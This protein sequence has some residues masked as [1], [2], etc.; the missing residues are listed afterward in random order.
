MVGLEPLGA[1][2][3]RRG[4]PA[5]RPRADRRRGR[6]GGGAGRPGRPRQPAPAAGVRTGSPGVQDYV[7][8]GGERQVGSARRFGALR[9]EPR[10]RGALRGRLRARGRGD[11][12]H[13]GDQPRASCSLR[14][15][16]LSIARSIVRPIRALSDG[17]RRI[18]QGETDSRDPRRRRPRR[19]R[20]A[21]A[22]AARDGRPP[23]AATRSSSSAS[24]P[25]SNAPTPSCSRERT[26]SCAAA[27]SCWSSS[28][29]RTGSPAST[30]TATSRTACASRSKRADRTGEPL[31]LLLIDID[32]FKALNDRHGHAV[33]DEVLR[34][35]ATLLNDSVRETDLP[36]RYGGEEFAVLAPRT[37]REGAIALAEKLARRRSAARFEA[38]GGARTA[39]SRHRL[40]R[41]RRLRRRRAA[42][43]QRRRSRALPG[44]GARAR[45]ACVFAGDVDGAEAA[46]RRAQRAEGERSSAEL[47][48]DEQRCVDPA[49]P[50]RRRAHERPVALAALR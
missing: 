48:R 35:V 8:A 27:T 49:D 18:A 30:T 12:Q 7:D 6:A 24:R 37:G 10:G 44:Q 33:G 22:R 36:A 43:L 40:D 47:R 11:P 1:P 21:L 42:L 28:P 38:E 9:L 4:E 16:A 45:T 5:Q 2:A 19:D 15:L 31:A 14:R 41:R 39:S 32:D 17:A 25:R 20:R 29:S 13:A 34:R 3:G 50:A 46:N 23:A 26:T